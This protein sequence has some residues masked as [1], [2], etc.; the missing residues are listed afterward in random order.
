VS[1]LGLPAGWFP[2]GLI[3]FIRSHSSQTDL[4]Q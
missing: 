2:T 3:H 4:Q 1:K